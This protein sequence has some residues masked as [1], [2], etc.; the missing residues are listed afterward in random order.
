MSAQHVKFMVLSIDGVPLGLLQQ[1]AAQGELPHL[2]GLIEQNGLHQMRSVQ[3]TVSCVAWSSY[4]TGA[5]PGKHGIFGFIDRR[6]GSY[7]LDFPNG[8]HMA[9][10]HLWDI[11]SRADKRV[12]GMNVPATYPPR[13]VNGILIG[14]FLAPSLDKVA[15]PASVGA[16]L[17]S[18]DYRIDSDAQ[19]ARQDKNAML[20]DLDVTLDRRMQAM[21]HFLDSE[22]WDIFHTHIM[23]SDRINHFL[24]G[25]FQA[26]DA[27]FAPAFRR[28]YR[29][30]DDY[31]GQ[32]LQRIGDDTPLLVLSD[33]GFCPIE[34]EVQLSRCLVETGWTTPADP[35]AHPLSIN[36][37]KSRAYCLIPGRIFINLKDREPAGIV[38]IE[39]YEQTRQALKADLLALQDPNT[40]RAVIKTV[41]MREQLYWPAGCQGPC[42]ASPEQTARCDGPFGRAADLIAIPHDGYDLK[43]GLG[44][45]TCF[46]QTALEGMHTYHDAF[47]IAR[48]VPLPSDNLEILMLARAILQRLGVEPPADMDGHGQAVTPLEI[49]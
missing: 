21:F 40:G 29:R 32:L 22:S 36:P 31:V 49:C 11:L 23:G 35:I 42:P 14:G 37:S 25:K 43:L 6:D 12:F 13:P 28:Y 30:I 18:I 33:H 16:Y 7:D 47:L 38:P 19:L 46:Q 48:D 39:E 10:P 26:D 27:H 2:A 17:K 9:T 24:L 3:P 41:V 20:G 4:M 34:Q 15:Y 44:G 5:N 1:L 8:R 45:N